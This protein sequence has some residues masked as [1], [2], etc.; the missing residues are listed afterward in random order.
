[1]KFVFLVVS[2]CAVGLFSVTSPT[3]RNSTD[4][5]NVAN[6]LM[7]LKHEIGWADVKQEIAASGQVECS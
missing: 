2:I 5:E 4:Q 6:E 7:L 3:E 1:M